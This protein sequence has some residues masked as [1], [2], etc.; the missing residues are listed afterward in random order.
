MSSKS[1]D[2][3]INRIARSLELVPTKMPS[4]GRLPRYRIQIPKN[5]KDLLVGTTLADKYYVLSVLGKGGMSV[6][7]KAKVLQTGQIVAIKTLRMQGL[8][9]ELTVKRFQREAEVLRLLDHPHIV[10]VFDY[11]TTKRG[12]PYFVMDYLTGVDLHRVIKREKNLSPERMKDIFMQVCGAVGHAHKNGFVHRDLKPGNIMLITHDGQKDYVKVVDFG[13]A[14]LKEE[15]QRLTRMG[16]VWGSPVYMS[17]EQCMGSNLDSRSDVY[18]LGIV[19]YEAL[20]GE[21]PFLGINYVDTMTKQ[22]SEQPPP[23]L[24]VRPDLNIPVRLEEIVMKALE[25][26]PENRYQSTIHIRRDLE[27]AMRPST[28]E[29]SKPKNRAP[30]QSGKHKTVSRNKMPAATAPSPSRRTKKNTREELSGSQKKRKRKVK[31]KSIIQLVSILAL[32]CLVSGISFAIGSNEKA[33]S[34][35]KSG[36][37]KLLDEDSSESSEAPKDFVRK[38]GINLDEDPKPSPASKKSGK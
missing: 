17:P 8:N 12:Q 2:N 16:E 35:I 10:R 27:A 14:K 34:F 22:I 5:A 21:V 13:I 7:Y 29:L 24:Q 20:T 37:T 32:L 30:V 6:V 31:M 18:S 4:T 23:F 38:G 26:N 9:D 15:V 33:M 11:Q 25:K 28:A 36:L 3:L 1:K 19:M